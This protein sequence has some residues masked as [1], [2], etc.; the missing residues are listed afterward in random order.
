MKLR[1][2]ALLLTALPS[3]AQTPYPAD[4]AALDEL[5]LLRHVSG[6]AMN[7]GTRL[8]HLVSGGDTWSFFHS[9]NAHLTYVSE[10]GPE[11]QRNETFSTNWLTAGIHGRFGERTS[12]VVRGRI[13]A[14]PYTIPEEGYPQILQYVSPEGGQVLLDRMRP[15]D[16]V[17]EAAAEIAFRTTQSSFL[18]L[19]AAAIGDPA[20]GAPPAALRASGTDFAEAPLSWDVQESFHNKTSVLTVGYSSKVLNLEYSIFHDAITTPDYTEIETD[21]D[22]DSSSARLTLMPT[23]NMAIQVSRGELGEDDLTK[24]EITSASIGYVTDA[25][26]A[27]ALWTRRESESGPASTAYGIELS[28]RAARSTI[29]GRAEWVDRPTDLFLTRDPFVPTVEETA[30]FT[31]GYLYDVLA[32]SRY[33]AGVGVNIDYHQN[34]RELE[35]LAEERYGHKPQSIYAFVRFRTR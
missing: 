9:F 1:L 25:V 8:P 24:R 35:E 19:Y 27:T 33:R 22:I 12:F 28:M 10:S 3:L 29:M 26:A 11:E 23:R 13:S 32:S 20:L 4:A 34:T 6:T 21:G 17:G 15:H 30:H 2:A 5:F 16:L 31:V 7:P 14:E 18:H